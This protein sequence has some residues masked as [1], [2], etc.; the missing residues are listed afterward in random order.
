[1][2]LTVNLKTSNAETLNNLSLREIVLCNMI[3]QSS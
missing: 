3:F 1:M 2:K